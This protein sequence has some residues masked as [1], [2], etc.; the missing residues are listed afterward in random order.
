MGAGTF[1]LLF[2]GLMGTGVPVAIAMAGSSLIFVMVTGNVPDFVVIHR[3]VNG[4]DSFPLLAVPF[5]ILAGNLMNSAGITNRIVAALV[6][7]MAS[8]EYLVQR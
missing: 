2:L 1:K 7:V 8:P 6:L 3:M 5:F 4:I